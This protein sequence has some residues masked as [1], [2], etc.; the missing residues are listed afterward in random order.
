MIRQAQPAPP[1]PCFGLEHASADARCQVCPHAT[2]CQKASG[3]LLN[4][5]PLSKVVYNLLPAAFQSLPTEMPDRSLVS[6]DG[7]F[8]EAH[9]VVYKRPS[10]HHLRPCDRHIVADAKN[11]GTT[12][13]MFMVALLWSY[14][15]TNPDAPFSPFNFGH[16]DSSSRVAAV[17]ETCLRKLASYDLRTMDKVLNQ[18][19][20]KG[21]LRQTLLADET[22][23]GKFIVSRKILAG[24]PSARA[25]FRALELKLGLDWLAIEPSYRT[26]IAEE[27]S[28]AEAV[29][30]HR[31]RVLLR[32]GELKRSK[33]LAVSVFQARELMAPE[34]VSRVLKEWNLEPRHLLTTNLPVTDMLNHWTR[35]GLCLQH[36]E[37]LRALNGQPNIYGITLHS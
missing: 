9:Q 24:G 19:L 26:F 18:D 4:K 35:I 36:L 7:F 8:Q 28:N 15:Q 10:T 23:A 17:K 33:A 2:G 3:P 5:I 1:L 37:C 16:S 20:F 11:L 30:E 12:P 21:S 32:H 22:M 14:Q 13:F 6:L 27:P 25:L 31:Q 29:R 34:A